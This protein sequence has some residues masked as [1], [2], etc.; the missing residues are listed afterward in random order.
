LDKDA[1]RRHDMILQKC[2]SSKKVE[3]IK[4]LN[5]KG[6]YN[7]AQGRGDIISLRQGFM[8]RCGSLALFDF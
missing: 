2:L 6:K 4:T 5:L 1:R 7:G 3:K 8:Q